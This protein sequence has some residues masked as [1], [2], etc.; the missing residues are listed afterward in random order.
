MFL[1][2]KNVAQALL[3]ATTA[4]DTRYYLD[5]LMVEKQDDG[6]VV[7]KATDGHMLLQHRS[8]AQLLEDFPA[9]AGASIG[10][11]AK[12]LIPSAILKTLTA[13]LNKTKT[14]IPV[15]QSLLI[16]DATAPAVEGGEPVDRAVVVAHQLDKQYVV[17]VQQDKDQQFPATDRLWELHRK[18]PTIE[19]TL[20]GEILNRLAAAAKATGAKSL[21]LRLPILNAQQAVGVEFGGAETGTIEGLV[22]PMR[23]S[24][25]ERDPVEIA[26]AGVSNIK[27]ADVRQ[28]LLKELRAYK[29]KLAKDKEPETVD[30]PAEATMVPVLGT[31]AEVETISP[32]VN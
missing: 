5:G 8:E 24:E 6:S 23:A 26:L 25:A 3:L 11:R 31:S 15:L 2:H 10:Q 20:G 13:V 19:V 7:T 30:V 22:M 14:P 1:L 21:L 4:E 29:R 27:D 17:T 32:T 28:R 9:V 18:E 16:G 12:A